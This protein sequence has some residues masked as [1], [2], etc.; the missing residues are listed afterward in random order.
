MAR[1]TAAAPAADAEFPNW[2]RSVA[3]I[4]LGAGVASFSM[5]FWVPFL[6]LYMKQLGAASDARALFW[7]ALGLSA[8]GIFRIVGGPFWGVLADR[9]GRKPMF[10]RALFGATATTLIAVVATEP[11][12]VTV[13]W[14]CQGF[15]SG[16]VPAA[17]SLTSVSVPQSKLSSGLGTVQGCQYIG[18]TLGPALGAVIAEVLGLRGAILGAALLPAIAATVVLVGIPRDR[19]APRTGAAGATT[20]PHWST[21]VRGPAGR[22]FILGLVLYF[23]VFMMGQLVRTVAPISISRITGVADRKLEIGIAFF[24]AGL[25]SVAGALGLARYVGRTGQTRVW[26]AALLVVS[27]LVHATL[28]V[29]G[30]VAV[31]IGAFALASLVQGAMLPAANTIIAASVPPE[32]RGT[33]FGIAASVQALSLIVGPMSAAA[34]AA[35]SL[36]LGFLSLAAVLVGVAVVTFTALREPDLTDRAPT[37]PPADEPDRRPSGA[38]A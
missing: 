31:F 6:P 24:V 16:F 23:F 2:R 19:T 34:F 3:F 10:V 20:L 15:F 9:Y 8:N 14:A 18:T 22:Q 33:A 30:S 1:V 37:P 4:G 38:P 5:N 17:V 28:G 32:R 35:L 21:L 7:V 25:A 12:H 26:I 36:E 27:A 29:A 13:A 11:W